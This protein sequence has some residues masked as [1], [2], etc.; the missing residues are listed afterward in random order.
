MWSRHIDFRKIFR[1]ICFRILLYFFY[2][3][4]L[5][6]LFQDFI[7]SLLGIVALFILESLL[8]RVSLFF[9]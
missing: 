6:D 5:G 9:S 2:K 4:L 3:D 8:L 1:R 7:L